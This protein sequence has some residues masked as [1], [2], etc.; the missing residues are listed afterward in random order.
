[1]NVK[2]IK[3]RGAYPLL[4]LPIDNTQKTDEDN[5]VSSNDWYT[6]DSVTSGYCLTIGRQYIV[7]GVMIYQSQARFLILNDQGN[8]YFMPSELFANSDIAMCWDW[9]ERHF[10]VD[11]MECKILASAE[12]I[13]SYDDLVSL[14]SLD[15]NAFRR[16]LDYKKFIDEYF[17]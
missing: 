11:N 10:Y 6:I 9:E 5:F 8:P 3:N 12:L 16:F 1:M 2:C 14:V 4:V 7:Y 17:I 13:S 15:E